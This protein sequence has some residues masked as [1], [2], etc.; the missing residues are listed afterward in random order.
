MVNK[1]IL[2]NYIDPILYPEWAIFARVIL[3]TTAYQAPDR[4]IIHENIPA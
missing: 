1:S 4:F 3:L 2:N